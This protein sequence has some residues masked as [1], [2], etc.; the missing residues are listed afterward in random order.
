MSQAEVSAG[1]KA[2]RAEMVKLWELRSWH[3]EGTEREGCAEKQVRRVGWLRVLE[4]FILFY[5][6]FCLF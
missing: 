3:W 4:D 1:I 2:G 6:I 5:F